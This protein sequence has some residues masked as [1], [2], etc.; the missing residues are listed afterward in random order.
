MGYKQRAYASQV[1]VE[2]IGACYYLNKAFEVAEK[3]AFF[4]FFYGFLLVKST[5]PFSH[6]T[7]NATGCPVF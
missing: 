2:R 6:R 7:N 3:I 4:F 5:V 1:V